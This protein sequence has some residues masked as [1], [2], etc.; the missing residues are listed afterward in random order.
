MRDRG[1]TLVEL[2][3]TI[4]ILGILVALAFPSFQGS[5]RT[6]RVAGSNNEL[7]ASLSLVRSEAVR[8]VRGGG[9]C[10]SAQG[11]ECDGTWADGWIVWQDVDGGVAAQFD[12]GTDLVVRHVD[13]RGGVDVGLANT[14]GA[15]ITAVGFDTRGRPVGASMPYAWTLTPDSCPT[16]GEF[17]RIIQ[18]TA[19]GQTKTLKG[20]C[21]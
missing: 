15:A 20:T 19:V 14:A 16:G 11:T 2:L 18:M 10:G 8:S 3:V 5:M 6:N 1:F 12:V 17:V 4:A 7:L 21:P 9:V 13:G